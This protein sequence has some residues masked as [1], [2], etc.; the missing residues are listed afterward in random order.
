[1]KRTLVL[2]PLALF[3]KRSE[4]LI[5]P[6]SPTKNRIMPPNLVYTKYERGL[7]RKL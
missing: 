3:P 5:L 6:P 7:Q 4:S 2:N 1:M